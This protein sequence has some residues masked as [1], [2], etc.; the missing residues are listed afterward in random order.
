MR[1]TVI[2]YMQGHERLLSDSRAPLERLLSDSRATLERLLLRLTGSSLEFERGTVSPHVCLPAS[3][4]YATGED[5]NHRIL[6]AQRRDAQRR[7][8]RRQAT[9]IAVAA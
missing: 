9:C 3:W 2:G 8:D 1:S 7:P 4:I 6:D 5:C